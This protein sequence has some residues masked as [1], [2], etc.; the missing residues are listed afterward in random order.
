MRYTSDDF[1]A[2]LSTLR[3]GG[4][5]LYPT[6]TIWGIGCDATNEAAVRRV[7]DIK[8]RDDSKALILLLDS[9]EH[10]RKYVSLERLPSDT[11]TGYLQPRDDEKPFAKP[12]TVI[13]PD[14][15]NLPLSLLASDGSAAIRLTR[16]EFSHNLCAALGSP[17][18][19]TSANLSGQPSPQCFAQIDQHIINAVDYVC[20]Y[21]QND[22][23]PAQPS[24]ILRL[25][26]T[27]DGKRTL[28]TIRP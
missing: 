13:Y 26:V 7:Y 3:N 17:L 15:Q 21:R 18:V 25:D 11:L 14:V 22:T 9:M 4:V 10:L 28:T 19:S 8:Q 27:A 1:N 12:V 6:D 24:T 2:A 5:I 20:R 16:E 23:T